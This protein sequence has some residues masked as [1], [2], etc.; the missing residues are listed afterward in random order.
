MDNAQEGQSC[1]DPD[2]SSYKVIRFLLRQGIPIA[3]GTAVGL[4][5]DEVVQVES[6]HDKELQFGA[7]VWLS[8]LATSG[9]ALLFY[10]LIDY[11]GFKRCM[12]WNS[13]SQQ[14]HDQSAQQLDDEIAIFAAPNQNAQE[15][16]PLVAKIE[17]KYTRIAK[18][19][20][21]YVA[22]FVPGVVIDTGFHYRNADHKLNPAIWLST[23][24]NSA[25]TLLARYT[26]DWALNSSCQP[27]KPKS[28]ERQPASINTPPSRTVLK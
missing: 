21:S 2:S 10:W 5:V 27:C 22:G 13:S 4:V 6:I 16:A 28:D 9:V 3:I 7:T 25:T 18:S 20:F 11:V 14:S 24:I 8:T 15:R 17:N 1:T 26:V 23:P 19:I 12:Q